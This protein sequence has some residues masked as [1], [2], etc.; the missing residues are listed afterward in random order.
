VLVRL[1][2][3]M[4]AL[5]ITRPEDLVPLLLRRDPLFTRLAIVEGLTTKKDINGEYFDRY[6]QMSTFDPADRAMIQRR[7]VEVCGSSVVFNQ[8]LSYCRAAA[9]QHQ[10]RWTCS[11]HPGAARTHTP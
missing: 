5:G 6:G 9:V 2:A 1:L 10:V 8:L 3:G 4:R 11:I 7:I